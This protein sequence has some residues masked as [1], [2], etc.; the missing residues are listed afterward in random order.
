[1]KKNDYLFAVA[2]VRAL[3]NSLLKQSD[4]EQLINAEDYNKAALLLSE[5][6][7]EIKGT[8][9]SVALDGELEKTWDYLV[10]AAPEAEALKAFIV[11]ND[12]QNLKARCF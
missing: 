2:S 11:K 6:G 7:Y 1:M 12:F 9:Y 3:E 5:K 8:D 10:K 4:L